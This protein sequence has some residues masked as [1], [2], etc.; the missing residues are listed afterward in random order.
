MT[1]AS[2][3]IISSSIRVHSTHIAWRY[4]D[5]ANVRR[6]SRFT[7]VAV[8]Q[9]NAQLLRFD[10]RL[11]PRL[12]SFC[13]TAHHRIRRQPSNQRRLLLTQRLVHPICRSLGSRREGTGERALICD[14]LR[15][16]QKIRGETRYSR[17]VHRARAQRSRPWR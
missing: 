1:S 3:T 17:H 7:F 5:V 11:H 14:V 6:R 9:S 15:S 8:S 16:F 12:V 13:F 10:Q 4:R 2:W